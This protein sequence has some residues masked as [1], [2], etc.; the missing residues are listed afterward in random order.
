MTDQ[1]LADIEAR[2]KAATPGPAV[3]ERWVNSFDQGEYIYWQCSCDE[4]EANA[5]LHSHA[6]TDVPSLVAEV[7]RLQVALAEAD[8]HSQK[9]EG[10]LWTQVNSW[11]NKNPTAMAAL[12]AGTAAVV[13]VEPTP[14]MIDAGWIDSDDVDPEDILYAMVGAGRLDKED[15]K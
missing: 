10:L 9:M 8:Q 7:R 14:E 3:A 4:T 11:A 15:E 13:P 6:H 1:E 5:I 2:A 12:V